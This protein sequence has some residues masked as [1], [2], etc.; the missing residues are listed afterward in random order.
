MSKVEDTCDSEAGDREVTFIY[1]GLGQ[2]VLILSSLSSFLQLGPAGGKGW[3]QCLDEKCEFGRMPA[4]AAA[5][6]G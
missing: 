3:G 2:I 1:A 4:A 6:M 5:R